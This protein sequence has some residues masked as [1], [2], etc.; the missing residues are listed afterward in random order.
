MFDLLHDNKLPEVKSEV[1]R[2]KSF[3]N[4]ES[5]QLFIETYSNNDRKK[6]RR[7]YRKHKTSLLDITYNLLY[8]LPEKQKEMDQYPLH[9]K[10]TETASRKRNSL[11]NYFFTYN[12][13]FDNIN[14]LAT[15]INEETH[16]LFGDQGAYAIGKQVLNHMAKMVSVHFKD[17]I[18]EPKTARVADTSFTKF[19]QLSFLQQSPKA[20]LKSQQ[21]ALLTKHTDTITRTKQAL[22]KLSTRTDKVELKDFDKLTKDINAIDKIIN[23]KDLSAE[24]HT[25]ENSWGRFFFGWLTGDNKKLANLKQL[26]QASTLIEEQTDTLKKAIVKQH[27]I[28]KAKG[29]FI[30]LQ[31]I[32]MTETHALSNDQITVW[33]ESL[34]LLFDDNKLINTLV[35]PALE[36]ITNKINDNISQSLQCSDGE[37]EQELK[38]PLQN[39]L[40]AILCEENKKREHCERLFMEH[41][42]EAMESI[43]DPVNGLAFCRKLI[44]CINQESSM[45]ATSL[46]RRH[47][48]F[49]AWLTLRNLKNKILTNTCSF[50]DTND[51]YTAIFTLLNEPMTTHMDD[52]V[53]SLFSRLSET[54]PEAVDNLL[55]KIIVNPSEKIPDHELNALKNILALFSKEKL[56]HLQNDNKFEQLCTLRNILITNIKLKINACKTSTQLH[57]L[58]EAL[59][60]IW[61][62]GILPRYATL[63]NQ[64]NEMTTWQTEQSHES[65]PE[66]L[67]C[68]NKSILTLHK[69]ALSNIT[70]KP[71]ESAQ[72]YF[73]PK[74][75]NT[76]LK[77]VIIQKR[78]DF[79]HDHLQDHDK[80]KLAFLRDNTGSNL[81]EF[82]KK[83]FLN[84]QTPL[85]PINLYS[86]GSSLVSDVLK[87][88]YDKME[89]LFKDGK[90]IEGTWLSDE[91]NEEIESIAHSFDQNL[92]TLFDKKSDNDKL[93]ASNQEAKA[94]FEAN[95]GISTDEIDINHLLLQWRF[96]SALQHDFQTLSHSERFMGKT[97]IAKMSH[98]IAEE[99]RY[100]H[101]FLG[102]MNEK[103]L[104]ILEDT[105]EHEPICRFKQNATN[106]N[107]DPALKRSALF[108]QL[109]ELVKQELVD[110]LNGA[111]VNVALMQSH[112]KFINKRL[113]LNTIEQ[114]ALEKFNIE[115]KDELGKALEWLLANDANN[116]TE[117]LA[118]IQ[119]NLAKTTNTIA[120]VKQLSQNILAQFPKE[121]GDYLRLIQQ[122]FTNRFEHSLPAIFDD[123]S[124]IDR[125]NYQLVEKLK[126]TPIYTLATTIISDDQLCSTF[127]LYKRQVPKT[128]WSIQ[129]YLKACYQLPGKC[130]RSIYQS[131]QNNLSY[132]SNRSLN[133]FKPQQQESNRG[134]HMT[135]FTP[136]NCSN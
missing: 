17:T 35:R 121:F 27:K 108:Q 99:P 136:K 28:E 14:E 131:A 106:N 86:Y 111:K 110:Y 81:Y 62:D 21:N 22:L 60:T 103:Q 97:M 90:N 95:A 49:T 77:D 12:N 63:V 44:A 38:I 59:E 31:K 5:E 16:F 7:L 65:L 72:I 82:C 114:S 25:L 71:N 48:Q 30:D 134:I 20:F 89:A 83:T 6:A 50:N 24:I 52:D 79:L 127:K 101:Y 13:I 115:L 11:D 112:A 85:T 117:E 55:K 8:K 122:H 1:Q 104:N 129:P 91:L 87:T 96:L 107:G 54:V 123:L 58:T 74:H 67:L 56:D 125:G 57:Y 126:G 105:F 23:E 88:R 94:R 41:C 26:K 100:I 46:K 43:S 42:Q 80:E 32:V 45:L 98:V 75:E 102:S 109:S 36:K 128:N 78:N 124:N 18:T 69:P 2:L 64:K 113:A 93:S 33:K 47:E 61:P 70:F 29:Q 116:A 118:F 3:D 39:Q 120:I 15:Y 9:P 53:K 37:F 135:T 68:D 130:A 84:N 51:I 66:S 76:E 73:I 34:T 132:Y 10:D 4:D 19:V 133:Y 40:T 92:N 119:Q